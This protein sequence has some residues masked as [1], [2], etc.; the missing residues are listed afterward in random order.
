MTNDD[1]DKLDPFLAKMAAVQAADKA[2]ERML[3]VAGISNGSWGDHVV[4][5]GSY[6]ESAHAPKAKGGR[7][8]G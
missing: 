5:S 1:L 2:R 7:G 8:M 6:I 4:S 3:Q